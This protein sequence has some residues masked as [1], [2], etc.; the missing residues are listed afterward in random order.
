MEFHRRKR[1]EITVS[2]AFCVHIDVMKYR[3]TDVSIQTLVDDLSFRPQRV[4]D[5]KTMGSHFKLFKSI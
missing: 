3:K 5:C 1:K 2:F 4:C